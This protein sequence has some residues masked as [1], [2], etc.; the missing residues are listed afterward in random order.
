MHHP[1]PLICKD[2]S[3]GRLIKAF[4]LLLLSSELLK[5]LL[6]ATGDELGVAEALV[7]SSIAEKLCG[8]FE[9]VL[10]VLV[11]DTSLLAQGLPVAGACTVE[12]DDEIVDGLGLWRHLAKGD[13]GAG[14]CGS[15]MVC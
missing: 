7:V 11:C 9:K 13:A 15:V 8:V 1:L 6:G 2:A 12:S 5:D 4:S 14:E 3:I 10:D